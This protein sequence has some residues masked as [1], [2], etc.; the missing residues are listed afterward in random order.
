MTTF[1]KGTLKKSYDQMNIDKY[2]IA[3]NIIEY[4]VISKLIFQKSYKL[5]HVKMQVKMFKI[6]IRTFW[7]Q[8]GRRKKY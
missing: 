2:R 1:I 8:L 6:D 7:S 3:A 4:H 5:F